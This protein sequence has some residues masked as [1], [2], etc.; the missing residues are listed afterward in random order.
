ML[1]WKKKGGGTAVIA[2]GNQNHKEELQ[3]CHLPL[4]TWVHAG[5]GLVL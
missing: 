4:V 5:L 3:F 1:Y 2:H